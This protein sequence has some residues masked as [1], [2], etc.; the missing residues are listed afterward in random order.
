MPSVMRMYMKNNNNFSREPPPCCQSFILF[1]SASNHNSIFHRFY[2]HIIGISSLFSRQ[3]T[4]DGGKTKALDEKLWRLLWRTNIWVSAS[5][6]LFSYPLL[7]GSRQ[8]NCFVCE[9]F[10]SRF[11]FS[12]TQLLHSWKWGLFVNISDVVAFFLALKCFFLSHLHV[13]FMQTGQ[14]ILYGKWC[15]RS[16]LWA[17]ISQGLY[18]LHPPTR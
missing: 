15:S 12:H 7:P 5:P 3:P 18:L 2:E 9:V 17:L 14:R 11:A 1:F 4:S 13:G 6:P 16:R 10:L 8:M